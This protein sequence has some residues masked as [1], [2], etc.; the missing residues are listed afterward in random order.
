MR[1]VCNSFVRGIAAASVIVALSISVS[2]A[3]REDRGRDRDPVFVK[4]VKKII[5]TL[6]DGLTIPKP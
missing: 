5:K 4:I 3:P 1:R 6:G 2:A